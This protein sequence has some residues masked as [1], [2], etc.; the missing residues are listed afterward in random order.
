MHLK[1][2]NMCARIGS[3]K[4]LRFFQ[5]RKLAILIRTAQITTPDKT[6]PILIQNKKIQIHCSIARI[7]DF[8]NTKDVCGLMTLSIIF[9]VFVLAIRAA[10]SSIIFRYWLNDSFALRSALYSCQCPCQQMVV[11]SSKWI[12]LDEL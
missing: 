3:L 12:H 1:S 11:K 5:N 2:L 4:G 6:D 8:K 9:I 10:K 7:A